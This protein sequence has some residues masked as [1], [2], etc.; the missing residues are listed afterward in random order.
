MS[1]TTS[2][3]PT[4]GQIPR[5]RVFQAAVPLIFPGA[6]LGLSGAVPPFDR[7]NV[8]GLGIGGR[9]ERNLESFLAQDDVQFRAICDARNECREA[10]KS[11]VDKHHGNNDCEMFG[12]MFE[13][14]E[15]RDIDA[16]LIATGDRW[17][18]L[19]SILTAKPVHEDDGGPAVRRCC[20]VRDE[21]RRIQADA[22]VHPDKR[23]LLSG[24]TLAQG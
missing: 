13:L 23:R 12:D 24:A 15:R 4:L 7:I 11:T 5:R 20:A 2:E 8:A 6:V 21:H 16:V 22:I 9:G 19:L 10:I 18:T 1:D 17:H 14:W 3:A